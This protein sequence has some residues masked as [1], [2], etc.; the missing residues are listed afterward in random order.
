MP[1]TETATSLPITWAHTIVKA[2][3]WV[4]LTLP[5]MI[6][7]PG[8]LSGI[9]ISPIP[10]R[11][12]ELNIRTSLATFIK[13]TAVRFKAPESS[14]M[15]SCAAKASNLFGAVTKGKPVKSAIFLATK[16]SYP[17]GVFKPVPTAVPPKASSA[18]ITKAFLMALILLSI[19][20]T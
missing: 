11:G 7:D 3:G 2:S 12:P 9:T 8:S 15:A 16:T 20:C 1:P 13:A 6:D 19:C 14:T 4:G 5:G 18:T 17:F 10:Q